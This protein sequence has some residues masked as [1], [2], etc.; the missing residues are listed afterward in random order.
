MNII[1]VKNT[2]YLA[3]TSLALFLSQA[4]A[5]HDEP[6][7][8]SMEVKTY[9]SD[10]NGFL[11]SFCHSS[12]FF[13]DIFLDGSVA[14]PIPVVIVGFKNNTQGI[15]RNIQA[16]IPDLP[17][18]T[19]ISQTPEANCSYLIQNDTCNI[20]F[21]ARGPATTNSIPVPVYG[22]NTTTSTI[23]INIV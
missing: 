18:G 3:L 21:T 23:N 12:L 10:S 9:S 19:T 17:M 22:D 1:Q 20:S 15:A 7:S 13:C 4:S 16:H 2:I 14:P 8:L 11:R 5:A 6:V